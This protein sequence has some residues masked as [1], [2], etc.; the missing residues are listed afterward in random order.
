MSVEHREAVKRLNATVAHAVAAGLKRHGVTEFFG[1]SIPSSVILAACEMGLRQVGYRAENAGGAMADGYARIARRIGV[2]MAQNGPAATLLVPPLAE[3]LK[4]SVPVLALVQ[5]VDRRSAD[6]N[7]FQELDHTALFSGV[8]KWLRRVDHASRIDDY[9]DMAIAAATSGRPGPAVLLLPFDLLH[10]AEVERAERHAVLGTCPLDRVVAEPARIDA[11]AELIAQAKRP[12]VIAGGGI[13]LSDAAAEL[14]ELQDKAHLP[15]ATTVMGKGAVD[16]HH[17]LSLGVATYFMGKGGMAR[18]QRGLIDEADLV[19]LAGTRTNQNGTDSWTLYPRSARYIHLDIDGQ[20]VGR[21]YE[22]VRL[23][24]DAKATLAAL[25]RRLTELDLGRHRARRAGLERRIAEGRAAHQTEAAAL[26]ASNQ[27]PIRP[28]RI[29]AELD[30]KL[31]ANTIIVADASYASIWIANYLTARHAGSRFLTP[32]GIAG[33]GWG[34]PMALGAKIAAPGS[35]VICVAGDGGFGHCWAELETARRMNVPLV[36][37]VLN[38]GVL[39]YQRDAEYV[40]YRASTDAVDFTA[41]DHAGIARCCGCDGHRIERPEELAPALED[42]LSA[43]RLTLLDVIVDPLARPP[44]TFYKDTFP[45][46]GG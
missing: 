2:V 33:L 28:E 26:L 8:S 32:R 7:A 42:A 30:R 37:I 46:A 45:W 43:D 19:L 24:G 10:E 11:A 36:L 1:Q 15:V 27:A 20:E 34:L 44:L 40:R 23:V 35:P 4:A 12:L 25:T 38:N 14:V 16:E 29:M 9:L 41:V 3:A 18:H 39:G 22:S 13:H 6:R 21:N 5:E 31:T 17:P